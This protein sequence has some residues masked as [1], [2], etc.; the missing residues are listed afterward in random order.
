MKKCFL[1][2]FFLLPIL[3]F[4]QDRVVNLAWIEDDSLISFKQAIYLEET[5]QTP[6]YSYIIPWTDVNMAPSIE[7]IILSSSPLN[8]KY[9]SQ[10]KPEYLNSK[11]HLSY[12]IVF[13]KKRPYL[14]VSFTP[15]FINPETK[16][17]EYI[18]SFNLKI[19]EEQQMAALK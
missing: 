13:E 3:I 14:Q 2:V 4:G 18:D 15:F 5:G 9:K 17:T 11:P 8:E 10:V 16:K 6:V 1:S 19:S 7:A 12:G